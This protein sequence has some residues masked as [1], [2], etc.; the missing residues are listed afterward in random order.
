[1]CD[2]QSFLDGAM[3]IAKA[4]D[5][6]AYSEVCLKEHASSH[7]LVIRG[8]GIT[9]PDMP[10]YFTQ[11]DPFEDFLNE[12]GLSRTGAPL[13]WFYWN[14]ASQPLLEGTNPV[15]EPF[16]F[17]VGYEVEAPETEVR[18]ASD[19]V[20][21]YL[22]HSLELLRVAAVFYRGSFPHQEHSAFV[23]AW[24][25]LVHQAS[26][27]GYSLTGRLYREIYHHL[28]YS[29]PSQSITEIQVEVVPSPS[30]SASGRH[31]EPR[32]YD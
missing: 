4:S 22:T 15:R 13:T 8:E 18:R 21:E 20:G 1:M 26:S 7:V 11:A 28:D 25:T 6:Y 2:V 19:S 12:S 16:D 9:F 10:D 14:D 27:M 30:G 24:M 31:G 3:P 23:E 32:R 17:E 5:H 29:D